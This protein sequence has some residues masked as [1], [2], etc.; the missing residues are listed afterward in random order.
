MEALGQQARYIPIENYDAQLW[1]A[2]RL[3]HQKGAVSF[4]AVALLNTLA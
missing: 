4:S 3:I 2:W 1:I